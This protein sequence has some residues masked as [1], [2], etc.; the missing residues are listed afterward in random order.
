MKKDTQQPD[1]DVYISG[2]IY[3]ITVSYIFSP[4]TFPYCSI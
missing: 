1:K 2:N 3:D 4:Y